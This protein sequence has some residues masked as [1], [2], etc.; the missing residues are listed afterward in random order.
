[1][2]VTKQNAETIYDRASDAAILATNEHLRQHGDADCCGF[3]WVKIRPARGAFV[4]YLKAN[5]I[6]RSSYTGGYEIWNP[7]R[8]GTQALTA[9]EKGADAFAEV[10]RE[11]GIDA[12]SGS[13]MD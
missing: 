6:G 1:M 2:K 7:S 10:L 5:N 13:R 11:F 4:S 12:Y 3:A 9:K 8:N